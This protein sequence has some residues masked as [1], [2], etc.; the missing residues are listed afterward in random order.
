[1]QLPIQVAIKLNGGQSG[2]M[3]GRR[4]NPA[5]VQSLGCGSQI[6]SEAARWCLVTD[7]HRRESEAAEGTARTVAVSDRIVL[8]SD[9]HD[10]L[11]KIMGII[12]TQ[13]SHSGRC[14]ELQEE[15][16]RMY[17]EVAPAFQRTDEVPLRV[18]AIG[19]RCPTTCSP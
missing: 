8:G 2:R 3:K 17:A 18:S 14:W 15:W 9:G 13:P 1:M 19:T 11:S 5:S 16:R 4:P 12:E 10:D 6:M 7:E